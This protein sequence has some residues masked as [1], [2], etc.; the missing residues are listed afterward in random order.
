MP[1]LSRPRDATAFCAAE[2]RNGDVVASVVAPG[3][4]QDSLIAQSA[5]VVDQDLQKGDTQ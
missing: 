3:A 2:E 1:N 4:L 5:A